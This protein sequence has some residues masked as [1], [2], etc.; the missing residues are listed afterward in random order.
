MKCHDPRSVWSRGV[1]RVEALRDNPDQLPG[2]RLFPVFAVD[3]EKQIHAR[4]FVPVE[5]TPAD[6]SEHFG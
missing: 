3:V 5:R 4:L 6:P 2:C 1:F